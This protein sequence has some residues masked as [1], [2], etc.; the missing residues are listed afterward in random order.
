MQNHAYVE[1]TYGFYRMCNCVLWVCLF[2]FDRVRASVDPANLCWYVGV[3][4]FKTHT[5][6]CRC[7]KNT[8]EFPRERASEKKKEEHDRKPRF[9]TSQAHIM[10]SLPNNFR[11]YIAYLPHAHSR[12]EQ[13]SALGLCLFDKKFAYDNRRA[14]GRECL[15]DVCGC[16]L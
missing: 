11:P 1:N 5:Q 9:R 8:A 10:F 6:H 3:I 15:V 12:H 4:A 16:G 7:E 2:L 13:H 14:L